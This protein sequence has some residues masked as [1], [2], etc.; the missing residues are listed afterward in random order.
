[1][2]TNNFR[3][4]LLLAAAIFCA[5][6]LSAADSIRVATIDLSLAASLHPRMALF[7]F[8]R[9]GFYK[10][11]PGLS[12]EAFAEAVVRLKNSPAAESLTARRLEIEQRLAVLDQQRAA[13]MAGLSS[14]VPDEAASLTVEIEK[15]V[16]EEQR[17]RG[18]LGDLDHAASCPELTAPAETRNILAGIETEILAIVRSVAEKGGY[19]LVLNSSIPVPYGYPVRYN[20]G[21]MYGQGVPGINFSLFYSFLAKNNLAHPLDETPP[22]RELIN[23]LE[24]T[25]YPEA[26]NLL[27]IKPYPLVLSGGHSILSEVVRQIYENYS[28]DPEVYK[29]VDSVIQKIEQLQNNG[30]TSLR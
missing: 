9:M 3:S 18:E 6:T 2:R 17:L 13:L 14:P 7:D 11:E 19:N 21:E 30:K 12:A 26:V 16:E 4:L 10:V 1:M 22:S 28:V 25:R 5:V 8:D 20:S 27:P 23:W 29:V 15:V 24:L